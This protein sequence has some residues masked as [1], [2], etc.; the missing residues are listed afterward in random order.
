GNT[1]IVVE[2]DEET[3]RCADEI[4]DF[5]PGPGVR[6][7]E[8]VAQGDI[9]AIVRSAQSVTGAFLSGQQTIPVPASRRPILP[10]ADRGVK[11][12]RLAKTAK[13]RDLAGRATRKSGGKR[14]ASSGRRHD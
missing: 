7:G 4:V 13:P 1:V 3:M 5:G 6:G 2:H 10:R 11:M 12:G 14:D 9:S 8:V